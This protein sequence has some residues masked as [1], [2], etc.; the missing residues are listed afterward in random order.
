MMK[1]LNPM[2]LLCFCCV[3][4]GGCE[5]DIYGPDWT[6]ID[7]NQVI[8]SI[9][10]PT[11]TLVDDSP[12]VTADAI[13]AQLGNP[14]EL[15]DDA[16]LLYQQMEVMLNVLE[17]SQ[18]IEQ[19]SN[20]A[21][22]GTVRGTTV[23]ARISCL[24]P[25]L[26]NRSKDFDTYGEIRLE[27]SDFSLNDAIKDGF[28]LGGDML[29]GFR[30]CRIKDK[31]MHG[32]NPAFASIENAEFLVDLDLLVKKTDATEYRAQYPFLVRRNEIIILADTGERGTYILSVQLGGNSVIAITI[33][34]AEGTY[35]CSIGVSGL[36]CNQP[37]V[38]NI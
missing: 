28:N 17:E 1:H 24:G 34:S 20:T 3:V 15:V 19:E 35:G 30:E 6:P 37:V 7:Y 2:A 26:L 18:G 14:L 38:D 13:V 33:T 9:A 10:G 23:Y 4:S 25:N 36:N 5:E 29:V 16:E 12:Q 27:G 11:G 8:Q 22:K 31:I 32:L 21:S